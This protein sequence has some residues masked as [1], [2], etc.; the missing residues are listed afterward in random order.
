MEEMKRSFQRSCNKSHQKMKITD[1]IIFKEKDIE[2][3]T[4]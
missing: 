3:E 4:T 2:R 1:V